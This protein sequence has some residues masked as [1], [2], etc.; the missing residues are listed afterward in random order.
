MLKIGSSE[1][2]VGTMVLGS[3]IV[4]LAVEL[5]ASRLVGTGSRGVGSV[6]V[7]GVVDEGEIEP[8]M[9]WKTPSMYSILSPISFRK[10]KASFGSSRMDSSRRSM[11]SMRRSARDWLVVAGATSLVV[12]CLGSKWW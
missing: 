8:I 3:A 10:F 7:V 4:A 11:F 12:V 9:L 6:G 1:T 2:G 5:M